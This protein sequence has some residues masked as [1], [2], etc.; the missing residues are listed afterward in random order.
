MLGWRSRHCFLSC[1]WIAAV[2]VGS[3]LLISA[4]HSAS[5]CL[6]VSLALDQ[7]RKPRLLNLECHHT[8]WFHTENSRSFL[9]WQLHR[10]LIEGAVSSVS[11]NL[12]I[13]L[14]ECAMQMVCLVRCIRAD[15]IMI[16]AESRH[17]ILSA[18]AQFCIWS[19]WLW[20]T[21]QQLN[22]LHLLC[23]SVL[24]FS[25]SALWQLYVAESTFYLPKIFSY[26]KIGV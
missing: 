4:A 7:R 15:A 8:E 2:G 12:T 13:Q 22:W 16:A 19:F 20:F 24:A 25:C 6:T 23:L 17:L 1:R 10:C 5:R 9:F 11:G 18:A 14:I 21:F 3:G 26:F